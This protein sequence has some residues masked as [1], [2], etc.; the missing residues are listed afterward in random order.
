MSYINAYVHATSVGLEVSEYARY[1]RNRVDYI[2][3]KRAVEMGYIGIP[4]PFCAQRIPYLDA[5]PLFQEL[6]VELRS[7][8]WGWLAYTE[9]PRI[10]T[11]S[12]AI[13]DSVLPNYV[14]LPEKNRPVLVRQICRETRNN[15]TSYGYVTFPN[16]VIQGNDVVVHS[17]LD[18]LYLTWPEHCTTPF[19]MDPET[20]TAALEAGRALS[21]LRS[22]A[23]CA[24]A[25]PLKGYLDVL[26]KITKLELVVLVAAR[27]PRNPDREDGKFVLKSFD[28]KLLGFFNEISLPELDE[29]GD[30]DYDC[31]EF[32][33]CSWHLNPRK[34]YSVFKFQGLLERRD[35]DGQGRMAPEVVIVDE[36][37]TSDGQEIRD[38]YEYE[39][40]HQNTFRT[41][42]DLYRTRRKYRPIHV[43]T[44]NRM[45]REELIVG[46][47]G[48]CRARYDEPPEKL[49]IWF[50]PVYD[51]DLFAE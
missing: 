11:M 36:N 24:T 49:R 28:S 15:V 31:V 29:Y 32:A 34:V 13:Y 5:F 44:E 18:M 7:L 50:S 41:W 51:L 10:V 26:R 25:T 40:H 21:R 12:W 9:E 46:H 19:S 22:V 47:L 6:P 37:V 27:V 45:S 30:F 2:D 3:E 17:D 20:L 35:V 16:P 38:H 14:L 4:A 48:C 8:I 43:D 39:V 42:T 23:F 33:S 1:H